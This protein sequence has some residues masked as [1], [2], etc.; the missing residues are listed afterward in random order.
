VYELL[1]AGAKT[2]EIAIGEPLT[3]AFVA[4]LLKAAAENKLE[5]VIREV[6]MPPSDAVAAAMEWLRTDGA[7][8]IVKQI[9]Q[10]IAD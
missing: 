7:F 8:E 3:L 2:S 9:E 5:E 4:L 6:E 1:V 10:R